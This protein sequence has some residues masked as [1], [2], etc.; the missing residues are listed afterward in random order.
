MAVLIDESV[1]E[2][3]QGHL[4]HGV[5][6][7]WQQVYRGL[8]GI[9]ASACV[10]PATWRMQISLRLGTLCTWYFIIQVNVDWYS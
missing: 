5:E 6:F 2:G 8:E 7:I 10:R 9:Y 1:L 3:F 4:R